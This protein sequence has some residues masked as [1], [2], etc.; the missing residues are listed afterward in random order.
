MA[1]ELRSLLQVSRDFV[2]EV[3]AIHGNNYPLP[4]RSHFYDLT[5]SRIRSQPG[6]FQ[7]ENPSL[8]KELSRVRAIVI[9]EK[10]VTR[11]AQV[12]PR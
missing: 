1:V 5:I 6:L 12:T 7:G 10:L 9:E 3:F 11:H 2:N 4:L 8:R